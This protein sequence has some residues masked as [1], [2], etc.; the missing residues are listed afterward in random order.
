M[1]S[2]LSDRQIECQKVSGSRKN[3]QE[4]LFQAHSPPADALLAEQLGR[5]QRKRAK[6]KEPLESHPAPTAIV[7]SG[8]GAARGK[9]ISLCDVIDS[10]EQVKSDFHAHAQ[11][12]AGPL[13]WLMALPA[14]SLSLMRLCVVLFFC[15]GFLPAE[16]DPHCSQLGGG[17]AAAVP[18]KRTEVKFCTAAGK[19]NYFGAKFSEALGKGKERSKPNPCC[20]RNACCGQIRGIMIPE[21]SRMA[22]PT[23]ELCKASSPPREGRLEQQ[24]VLDSCSQKSATAFPPLLLQPEACVV[25]D[26]PTLTCSHSATPTPL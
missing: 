12:P 4:W 20:F 19:A 13:L 10:T 14:H 21:G 2:V 9:V 6:P 18:L 23:L 5:A 25:S 7:R 16:Q 8:K 1:K 24:V 22:L 15:S 3:K 26:A 11:S 17:C